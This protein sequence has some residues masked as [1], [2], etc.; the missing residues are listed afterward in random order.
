V[1]WA[2]PILQ[3]PLQVRDG[4]VCPPERAGNGMSWNLDAVKRYRVV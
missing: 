1:D 4:R 3:Q 2:H